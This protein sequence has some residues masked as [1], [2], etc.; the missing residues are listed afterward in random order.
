MRKDAEMHAAE[1]AKRHEDAEVRNKADSLAFQV[2]KTLKDAGDKIA[3]D[4]KA[5]VEAALNE[6]KE[7]LKGTDTA[8]IKAK[9]DALMKA[10]EPVAQE[11]YAHAQPS[12]AQPGAGTPPPGGFSQGSGTPPPN[13]GGDAKKGGDDVVDADYTMK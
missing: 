2:E 7:A 3:A 1:D 10:M 5:P 13:N 9:E 6:L 11:M 4:K 8:A 12:G